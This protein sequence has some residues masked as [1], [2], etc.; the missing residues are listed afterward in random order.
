MQWGHQLLAKPTW[1]E[2]VKTCVDV[3]K[4]DIN[5]TE[6]MMLEMK[7]GSEI[8]NLNPYAVSYPVCVE[9]QVTGK[10]V[11]GVGSRQQMIWALNY[12]LPDYMKSVIMPTTAE[13]YEPCE[14]D[15]TVTYL[16]RADVKAAIHVHSDITWEECSRVLRYNMADRLIPMMPIYQKLLDS[17]AGLNILVY[18]GDDD[19][20]CGTIGTQEWIWNLGYEPVSKKE[21][22]ATWLY[23]GQTAGFSTKFNVNNGKNNKFTFLTVHKAGHEVPA[24]VPAEGFDLFEKYLSGY[25]FQ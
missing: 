7:M 10:K 23:N 15:Y 3:P 16:N 11:R 25:W 18:S 9:D 17:D 22:W 2:Y 13:E 12:M 1:D 4:R 6:C 5:A 19:A 24:Y 14:S 21:T 8:G 20:V